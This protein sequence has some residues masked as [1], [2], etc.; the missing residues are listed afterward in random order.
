[1]GLTGDGGIERKA[2]LIGRERFRDVVG[3]TESLAG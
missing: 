3:L 2:I 1:M